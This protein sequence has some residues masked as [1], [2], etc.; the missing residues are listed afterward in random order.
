MKLF[1]ILIQNL[2]FNTNTNTNTNSNEKIT[3]LID[4]LNLTNCLIFNKSIKIIKLNRK[5]NQESHKLIKNNFYLKDILHSLELNKSLS[6]E[7][8]EIDLSIFFK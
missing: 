2:E 4:I 1:L 3:D 8:L 5:I 7:I 6:I